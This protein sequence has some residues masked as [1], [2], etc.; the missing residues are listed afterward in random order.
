MCTVP[1]TVLTSQILEECHLA[2]KA[3]YTTLMKPLK[4]IISLD[5]ISQIC[6]R[7]NLCC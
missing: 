5:W 3:T 2:G 6:P 4:K 7:I 1:L